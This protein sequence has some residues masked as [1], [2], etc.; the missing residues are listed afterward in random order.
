MLSSSRLWSTVDKNQAVGSVEFQRK[1]ARYGIRHHHHHHLW[2]LF[3]RSAIDE[4][5]GNKDRTASKAA[6]NV[7]RTPGRNGPQA[8]RTP[9][10]RTAKDTWGLHQPRQR[11]RPR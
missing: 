4:P 5:G 9:A 6:A 1:Q 8:C 2:P 11:H 7:P 10:R 3:S